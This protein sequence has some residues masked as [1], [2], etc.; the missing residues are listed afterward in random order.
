MTRYAALLA[1]ILFLTAASAQEPKSI[2]T[3]KVTQSL[4][5]TALYEVKNDGTVLIDWDEVEALAASKQNPLL[6]PQAQVMLA[7]RDGKWK[8]MDHAK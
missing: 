6:L 7:I 4:N 3:V 2:K 8:A 5:D 1:S